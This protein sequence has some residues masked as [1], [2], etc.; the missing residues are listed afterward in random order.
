MRAV[1]EGVAFNARW[2]QDAVE[3]FVRRKLPVLRILG[4]GATSDLWCQMHADVLNRRVERV[5][6]PMHA[7]VRGAGLFAAM[8][9]GR[10]MLD[11]VS[12]LVPVSARFEPE[13][14]ARA[15]YEP[16]YGEYRRLYGR[17]KGFYAQVNSRA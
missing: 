2:L 8:A 4:G 12:A 11:D 9:L 10:L 5:A 6:Q 1:L 14:S 15:V 13:P 17:L 16:M 7:N 3:K